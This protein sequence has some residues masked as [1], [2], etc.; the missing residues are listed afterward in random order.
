MAHDIEPGN[1]RGA[2]LSWSPN[3]DVVSHNPDTIDISDDMG[4]Q[5]IPAYPFVHYLPVHNPG[6]SVSLTCLQK[7]MVKYRLV[8]ETPAAVSGCPLW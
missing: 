5:S 6:H 8:V 7:Q 1:P 4:Q 3:S 2:L